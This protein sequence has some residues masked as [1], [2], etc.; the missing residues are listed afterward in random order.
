MDPSVLIESTGLQELSRKKAYDLSLWAT[1]LYVMVVMQPPAGLNV[2][3]N[4]TFII[5]FY[6]LLIRVDLML[7]PSA[8]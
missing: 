2:S 1:V 7:Q 5:Y 4:T 6:T 3:H 8:L